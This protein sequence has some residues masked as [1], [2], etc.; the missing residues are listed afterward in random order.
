[1]RRKGIEDHGRWLVYEDP[2]LGELEIM[3]LVSVEELTEDDFAKLSCRLY[4]PVA[5]LKKDLRRAFCGGSDGV[6]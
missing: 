2:V 3:L 6:L 5:D 1:M 4:V